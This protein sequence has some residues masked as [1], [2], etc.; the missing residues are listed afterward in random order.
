MDPKKDLKKIRRIILGLECPKC[1]S[2][3]V[4][5]ENGYLVCESCGF[6]WKPIGEY[7]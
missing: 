2:T 6:R 3:S 4:I 5:W 1:K 7:K